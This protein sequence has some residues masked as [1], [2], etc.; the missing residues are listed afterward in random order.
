MTDIDKKLEQARANAKGYGNKRGRKETA[1]DYLKG[2]YAQQ[3]DEVKGLMVGAT[4]S[5][6]D[7]A[8]RNTEAYHDAIDE[9]AKRYAEWTAAEIYMKV[10]F[11]EADV[12]RSEQATNRSMDRAHQ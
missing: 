11:A 5:A 12:W 1:D 10:L 3:Y 7:A 8:V 6:I 2:V 4:V 9:K